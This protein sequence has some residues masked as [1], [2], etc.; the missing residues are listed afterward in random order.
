MFFKQLL[1]GLTSNKQSQT[2]PLSDLISQIEQYSKPALHLVR[3]QEKVFSKLG[4]KPVLPLNVTWPEWN[5]M[6]LSFIAQ[7]KCSEINAHNELPYFPS[8][9]LFYIFYDQ[10]QS[11]WGFDPEEKES[12]K[13]MFFENEN[14]KT[15]EMDI[16]DKVKSHGIYSELFVTGYKINTYPSYVRDLHLTNEQD[17][18]YCSYKLEAF[19]NKPKHIIGGYPN[20]QQGDDMDLECQLVSHGIYCGDAQGYNKPEAIGLKNGREDWMLLFQIDSDDNAKMMWGDV[21][22]LY[23][24]IKKEDLKRRYFSDVWMILQCG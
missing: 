16:P 15:N 18:F 5:D 3:N 7:F 1:L 13:V 20:P 6:P 22:M 23:F 19:K 4:G 8:E 24:W 17:D 2:K 21:G 12:W 14:Q 11:T 10:D 9:G